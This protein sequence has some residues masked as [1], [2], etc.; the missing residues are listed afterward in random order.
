MAIL[1]KS[2]FDILLWDVVGTFAAGLSS[3]DP[4]PQIS[5]PLFCSRLAGFTPG[6]IIPQNPKP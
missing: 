5:E 6:S 2:P 4:R 3:G 1:V